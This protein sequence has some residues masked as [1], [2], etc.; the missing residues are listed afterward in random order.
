[1]L[2][3]VKQIKSSNIVESITRKNDHT[4]YTTN[5]TT[6]VTSTHHG[7]YLTC[8]ENS[9]A[10]NPSLYGVDWMHDSFPKR[11]SNT[12]PQKLS[13]HCITISQNQ[14]LKTKIKLQFLEHAFLSSRTENFPNKFKNFDR[15]IKFQNARLNLIEV[16]MDLKA[17]RR[18][19]GEFVS[20]ARGFSER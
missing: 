9:L 20:A 19:F 5:K 1:M 10:L 7:S 3:H 4:K 12:S 15:R 2:Q 14:K 11:P 13:P 17:Y 8:T 6:Y 16:W 18:S